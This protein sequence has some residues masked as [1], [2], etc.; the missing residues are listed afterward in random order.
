MILTVFNSKLV[1]FAKAGDSKRLGVL[2]YFLSQ[3]KN[4]EIE[5]RPKHE[6][7]TDEVV[8]K[9]L[10]KQIKDRKESIDLYTKANRTDLV[11][12]E[13]S[14]LEVLEEFKSVFPPE[15]LVEPEYPRKNVQNK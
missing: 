10:K 3:V 2:R 11:E 9:V 12:K 5:M 1:E 8:L 4:K 7:L 14:E 6:E 13:S 15:M